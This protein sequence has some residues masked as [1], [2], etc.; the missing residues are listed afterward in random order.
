MWSGHDRPPEWHALAAWFA[1]KHESGSHREI[2]FA[3]YEGQV[4]G[5]T[6]VDD[7]ADAIEITVGI[8]G[9]EAG[10]GLGSN[11]LRQVMAVIRGKHAGKEVRC[12]L[13]LENA[14]GIRAFE[15]AGFRRDDTKPPR[16]FEMPF[17]TG[18]AM[19]HCW[20]H[21]AAARA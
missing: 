6:Y 18:S 4:L 15:A 14:A 17:S 2:Y 21:H 16:P 5:Y 7:L 1:A 10:R 20:V 8:S 19:Q 9:R 12:W 3:E 13:F 11:L